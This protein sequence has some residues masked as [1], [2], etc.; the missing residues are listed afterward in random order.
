M[1]L[2]TPPSRSSLP[3]ITPEEQQGLLRGIVLERTRPWNTTL[4]FA[5]FFMPA[6]WLLLTGLFVFLGRGFFALFDALAWSVL[7]STGTTLLFHI[8]YPMLLDPPRLRLRNETLQLQTRPKQIWSLPLDAPFEVHIFYREH[9]EDALLIINPEDLPPLYLYGRYRNHRTMPHDAI[10]VT[11]L[12]FSLA[13]VAIDQMGAWMM[14]DKEEEYI[15]PLVAC[16]VGAHGH[17]RKC[18]TLPILPSPTTLHMSP[19]EITLYRQSDRKV[20]LVPQAADVTAFSSPSASKPSE[21]PK[22]LLSIDVSD[23]PT[24]WVLVEWPAPLNLSNFPSKVLQSSDE[25]I[26]LTTLDAVLFLHYLDQLDLFP[27]A[28]SLLQRKRD[29]SEVEEVSIEIETT[30][31]LP[32]GSVPLELAEDEIGHIQ[33]S[34]S[35]ESKLEVTL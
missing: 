20:I 7:L 10:P 27:D 16:L 4:R 23:A 17:Q 25:L 30:A 14:P 24:L 31:S 26:Q 28:M 1:T 5:L 12:G 2:N 29:P 34:L 35:D 15:A 11:P 6:L 21:D 19:D 8:F 32:P 3:V 22:L 13:E 9:K 33:D 18:Y